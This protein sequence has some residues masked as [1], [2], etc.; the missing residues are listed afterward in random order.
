MLVF[1]F[2]ISGEVI[3]A[4][5]RCNEPIQIP[6]FGEERLIVKF[7]DEYSEQSY[8]VQII[9]ESESKFDTAPFLYEFIHLLLPMRRIHPEDEKSDSACAQTV[10]D[11]IEELSQK[12]KEDPRWEKLK[13]LGM[14][15]EK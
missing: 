9:P 14:K 1:L 2:S 11:K 4:C 15:N 12:P 10:M 6:L 3:L 8:E 5:D 7:G 13:E